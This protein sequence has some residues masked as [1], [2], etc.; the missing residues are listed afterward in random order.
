MTLLR[1]T[2]H[3]LT[4]AL[5][6]DLRHQEK[7]VDRRYGSI[8]A[9]QY[10]SSRGRNVR[11]GPAVQ[12]QNDQAESTASSEVSMLEKFIRT[13]PS[14]HE[15]EKIQASEC[16]PK[17]LEHLMS[18]RETPQGSDLQSYEIKLG[19][20]ESRERASAQSVATASELDIAPE[21]MVSSPHT[22]ESVH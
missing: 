4:E 9:L 15:E 19:I 8:Q 7:M 22:V 1:A 5:K 14:E 13:I 20:V 10:A 12:G 18:M 21:S 6:V 16:L 11:G 17:L 2:L 3:C